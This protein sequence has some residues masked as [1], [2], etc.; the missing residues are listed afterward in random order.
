MRSIITSA[1]LTGLV[2]CTYYLAVAKPPSAS[3]VTG[4]Y[5]DMRLQP[6][7]SDLLGIEVFVVS[8]RSGYQVVFQDA[9]GSPSVPLV[10]PARIDN[11][12]IEFELPQRAGYSGKFSG[13]ITRYGIKGEFADGQLSSSGEKSFIL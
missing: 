3:K 5:S 11:V 13:Q 6:Q 10:V 1:T 12:H 7:T 4:M 8:S 9:E 2:L